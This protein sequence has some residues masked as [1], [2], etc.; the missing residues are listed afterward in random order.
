M[1]AKGCLIK[2]IPIWVCLGFNVLVLVG[3]KQSKGKAAILGPLTKER[4]IGL[5]R[6][7]LVGGIAA[8]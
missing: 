8:D 2:F 3:L 5:T 6:V 7:S 4:P 1:S